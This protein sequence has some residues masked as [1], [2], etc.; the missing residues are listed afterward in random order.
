MSE[1]LPSDP[2][3]IAAD[4]ARELREHP[5]RW[6]QGHWAR[7]SSGNKVNWKDDAAVCWCLE[8]HINKRGGD[9]GDFAWAAGTMDP[10][11]VTTGLATLNDRKSTT[12]DRMI[13]LC[14]QVANG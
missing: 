1:Q 7:D 13:E 5:E 2:K 4:I 10:D 9:T 8:G 11:G 3:S 6:T 12:V 14:E